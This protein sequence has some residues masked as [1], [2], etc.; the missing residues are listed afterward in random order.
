MRYGTLV[1]GQ[2]VPAPNPLLIGRQVIYNPPDALYEKAGIR[3][4]WPDT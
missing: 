2:P 4:R 1:G 3:E